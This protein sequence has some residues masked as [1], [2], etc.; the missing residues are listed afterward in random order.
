MSRLMKII[1]TA[2]EYYPDK[3]SGSARLAFDEAIFLAKLGHEVWVVTQD[4]D[5]NQSEYRSQDGL[6]V[7]RY[8]APQY[9]RFDPRRTQE[10]QKRARNLMLRYIGRSVDIVHGHSLLHYEAARS[11]YG[12]HARTC[13]SVHSP[14][15]LELL[16]EGR[17]ARLTERLRAALRA[18]LTHSIE[19]Q[20]LV[21]SESV[22]AF[23][24][25]T[26]GLLGKLHGAEVLRKTEVIPG[27]VNMEQFR[28]LS[29][30]NA[31]KSVL[32][33]PTD[34]PIFFT[35]RRLVPRM[36]LNRLIQAI[37]QVKSAGLRLGM[38]IGGAGPLRAQLED[39]VSE[40]DL[41][42]DVCFAGRVPETQLALMYGAADAF[43]LPTAE[44]ECFGLIT[45]ESLSCGRPVLATPI[46]ATPEILNQFE[47]GWLAKDAT[48]KAI[49]CLLIRYLRNELP[50]HD[51]AA[52]R[53]GVATHFSRELVLK[54]L[55][56]TCL[57]LE[58]SH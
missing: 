46:G 37:R 1:V 12:D 50:V 24:N 30:R 32:G 17:S 34:R 39:L 20:C 53:V 5:G 15:R 27:W 2:L 54:R 23:S 42:D 4:N 28:I 49:A 40:L 18:H 16:A 8:R 33:W 21:G 6:H 31:A 29:D 38:V 26:R 52:L 58:A 9:S 45:L 11:I 22:T 43:V 47:P 44:L 36:G 25:Y 51:P 35:L 19:H 7:L 10:H 55:V 3:P 41:N 56:T 57:G 14:I 48:G 13:Y